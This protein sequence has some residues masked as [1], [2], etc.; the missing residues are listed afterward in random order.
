MAPQSESRLP[1]TLAEFV[2]F[3]SGT[4][5]IGSQDGR[6]EPRPPAPEK[7]RRKPRLSAPEVV[8]VDEGP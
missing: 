2:G 5:A 4:E 1:R 8:A 7:G 6:R 3:S